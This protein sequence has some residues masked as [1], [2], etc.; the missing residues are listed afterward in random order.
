MT[1]LSS[2]E[3]DIFFMLKQYIK[4]AESKFVI[5]WKVHE[6]LQYMEWLNYECFSAMMW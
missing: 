3:Q 2:F 6:T 5:Y 1:N 4:E